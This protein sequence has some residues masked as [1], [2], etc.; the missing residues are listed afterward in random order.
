MWHQK[1]RHSRAAAA[2]CCTT[3]TTNHQIIET[4]FTEWITIQ[5][6]HITIAQSSHSFRGLLQG[7][8]PSIYCILCLIWM[9]PS[10]SVWEGT[11]SPQ[12]VK[13]RLSPCCQGPDWLKEVE[14]SI[15]PASAVSPLYVSTVCHPHCLMDLMDILNKQRRLNMHVVP[16]FSWLTSTNG[17]R[18]VLALWFLLRLVG[19]G[20]DNVY[21]WSDQNVLHTVC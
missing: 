16:F 19:F 9:F 5:L 6:L 3:Q 20:L 14:K 21:L 17:H 4:E 8:L 7:R 1:H 15:C 18:S 12:R 10:G 11:L 13:G 2:Y